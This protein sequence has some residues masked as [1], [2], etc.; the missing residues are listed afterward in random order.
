MCG[1]VTRLGI[2]CGIPTPTNAILYHALLPLERRARGELAFV[3]R[4][5]PF[6][7]F[8]EYAARVGSRINLALVVFAAAFLPACDERVEPRQAIDAADPIDAAACTGT[9]APLAACTDSAECSSCL[10]RLFG[11]NKKCS[12]TCT[13][14]ADCPAPFSGCTNGF[15]A[16]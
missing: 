8:V 10:C 16:P 15:C 13:G 1:A 6:S 14:P 5:S 7:C 11:H 2:E 12:K 4:K 3:T 9:A